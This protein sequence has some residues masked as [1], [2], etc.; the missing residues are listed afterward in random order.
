MYGLYLSK[1]IYLIVN[2]C[3]TSL[4]NVKSLVYNVEEIIFFLAIHVLFEHHF[5]LLHSIQI[6]GGRLF[7]KVGSKI[8]LCT[9]LVL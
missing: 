7:E 6:V 9:K 5:F 2:K 1:I 3:K 4:L 8:Y